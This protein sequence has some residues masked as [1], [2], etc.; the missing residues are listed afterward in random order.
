MN[1][2]VCKI[3]MVTRPGIPDQDVSEHLINVFLHQAVGFYGYNLP[4]VQTLLKHID[5]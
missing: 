3:A 2:V 1:N 4:K 5:E